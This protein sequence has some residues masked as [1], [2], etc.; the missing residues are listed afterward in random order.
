MYLIPLFAMSSVILNIM[1]SDP[2]RQIRTI[3]L[4]R[5]QSRNLTIMSI[6]LKALRI[7]KSITNIKAT[8]YLKNTKKPFKLDISQLER[9]FRSHAFIQV[10]VLIFEFSRSYSM[11]NIDFATASATLMPSIPADNMPP[12][13]PAP[14]PAGNKPLVLMLWNSLLRLMLIGDDVLVSTP[15]SKPS[16][17][18]NPWIFLLNAGMASRMASIAKSGNALLKS[19]IIHYQIFYFMQ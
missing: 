11:F 6:Q 16:S 15:V 8:L 10:S 7:S 18:E 12:A 14:S 1:S 5:F 19:V 4:G 13:Q 17:D 9:L 3:N 2:C